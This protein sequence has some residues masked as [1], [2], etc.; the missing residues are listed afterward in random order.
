MIVQENSVDQVPG[1]DASLLSSYNDRIRPLLDAIDK[2][3]DLNVMQ[4]GIQLPT[5]VVVGDQSSGKSSVLESLAVAGISLPRGDGICTRVPLVIRLQNHAQSDS[6]LQLEY[7]TKVVPTDE[8]SVAKAIN[9]A[10]DEIAGNGKGISHTPLTLVVKKNGV[11]D[12]TMID[13]P[14]ITRVPVHG[15]PED[16]YEQ[17]SEM[18]MEFVKP[19][20][21]IILNV[22]SA[23][24]DF[25]TCESIRMSQLVDKT[26]ERTLAV[27]MKSD[28]APDGL[29]E[30]VMAD[31]VK[32][33]LGYV[34]VRNR[35]GD[36]SYEEARMKETKLFQAH[37][38]LKKIDKSMVSVPVLAKRLV[39]IQANIISK[40]L[41]DIVKKINVKLNANVSELNNLP[42]KLSTIA[43]AIAIFM[44]IVGFSRESLKKLL[45]RGEFD[46]YPDDKSMH[47]TARLAEMLDKFSEEIKSS[48]DNG[49]SEK[50][51]ID[52]I[53]V[54]KETKAIALPNFLPRSAFHA[55]LQ[56]K[57][58]AISEMAA[59]FIAEVW[60]YVETVV[61]GVVEQHCEKYPQ[62]Q[63]HMTRAAHN[64]ISSVKE[65]STER[66]LE[67]VEMEKMGGY[68]SDPQYLT[69]WKNLMSCSGNFNQNY[70]VIN[71]GHFGSID[72]THLWSYPA[73]IRHDA[74]DLKCRMTAYWKI[75]LKRM[76]DCIALQLML[77]IQRF[78]NGK[79]ESEV[80]NEV[81]DTKEGGIERVLIEM[82]SVAGK[83]ERLN[84]SISLLKESRIVLAKIM[85]MA[86]A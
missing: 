41:P 15:Q 81:M 61:I 29:H 26:G 59:D 54:L 1:V 22:L 43:E 37:P 33:G 53:E 44:R 39:E 68:T 9:M 10:T 17:I 3:R 85:D 71:L 46:E 7:L 64:L 72:V 32:I 28:K 47:C 18:I 20:E 35:I 30:K 84:K 76:V 42:R 21:S 27:V 69:E 48:S 36:E 6:S 82:P 23:T 79:M 75:V 16:I 40:C 14:G 45:V 34:C 25:P 83:R 67:V 31:D 63:S 19:E 56:L 60:D 55:L 50:F 73:G 58:K 65:K 62:F 66:V 2:L 51:L 8:L 24:V 86:D 49:S 74:F 38:L 5:I 11:P 78:A 57:I 70:T 12:L 77:S 80:V 52:E 4:E 13:L